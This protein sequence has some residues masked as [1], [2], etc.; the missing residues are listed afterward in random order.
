[1][2]T[3]GMGDV[4]TVSY[5]GVGLVKYAIDRPTEGR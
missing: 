1:M 4:G 3:C 5:F 2:E